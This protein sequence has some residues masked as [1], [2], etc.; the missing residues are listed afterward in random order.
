MYST[1]QTCQLTASIS[2]T[3]NNINELVGNSYIH[4]GC[5]L[6][7]VN[8]YK[9][10]RKQFMLLNYVCLPAHFYQC[11]ICSVQNTYNNN[12]AFCSQLCKTG[13]SRFHRVSPVER[14]TCAKQVA[15]A[16]MVVP[17]GG[18]QRACQAYRRKRVKPAD[19]RALFFSLM[20]QSTR[21]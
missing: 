21:T 5:K 2:C 13:S 18:R 6:G 9:C 3:Y 17:H 19:V 16:N 15:A 12:C 20:L 7:T 8:R 1:L 4:T 10:L 11:K 14:L